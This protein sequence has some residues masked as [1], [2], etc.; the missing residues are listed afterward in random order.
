[1][2]A[3][4]NTS[5]LTAAT[6]A[7]LPYSVS[8]D[9]RD[10]GVTYDVWYRWTAP[11][12][13]VV[14][15]WGR[16]QTYGAYQVQVDIYEDADV[17]LYLNLGQLW[18]PVNVPI[19]VPMRSGHVYYMNFYTI[20]SLDANPAV[21]EL[22]VTDG[23]TDAIRAG[24]F[25]TNLEVDFDSEYPVAV[26]AGDADRTVRAY[27]QVSTPV[28]P[29]GTGGLPHGAIGAIFSNGNVAWGDEQYSNVK[30]YDASLT[31][32][33]TILNASGL[34]NL[35]L[36][37]VLQRLY[38]ASVGAPAGHI[39]ITSYDDAGVV[40]NTWD[41]TITTIRSMGVN[42]DETILYYSRGGEAA[43]KRW[44][45]I[46]NSAMADLAAD[47]A[48]YTIQDVLVLEDDT[49]IAL[50]HQDA[51]TFHDAYARHYSA[52]GALLQTY[53]FGSFWRGSL[54]PPRAGFALDSPTSFW[55]SL[56]PEG[57]FDTSLLKNVLISNGSIVTTR[58]HSNFLGGISLNGYDQAFGK[59]PGGATTLLTAAFD[60]TVTIAI[61]VQET[62]ADNGSAQPQFTLG[63]TATPDAFFAAATFVD[64]VA[65]TG[66]TTDAVLAAGDDLVVTVVAGTG[67]STG[68]LHVGLYIPDSISDYGG[69]K[70][71]A[72]LVA[73]V[74]SAG[75]PA[76]PSGPSALA[77]LRASGRLG[78]SN[79]VRVRR[80][81]HLADEAERIFYSKFQLDCEAGV[82]TVSGQ[83]QT[84]T[85]ELRW[86][87]D[88]GFTWSAW[89]TLG[90]GP[91]GQYRFRAMAWRLGYARDRVFE[92]RQ[93]DPVKTTWL[94]AYLDLD[95]G[96][97]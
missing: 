17:S 32:V 67:G 77:A 66:F 62:L 39:D 78:E 33:S 84:P 72:V 93:S 31:L 30:I 25:L 90:V 15:I 22:S 45:L 96:G 64:A 46:L 12:D 80:A 41:T 95:G 10:A 97:A 9:V 56:K 74:G 38:I 71:Y 52:A 6:I 88:G 3:P 8:Q 26:L 89:R 21:L 7:S 2:P 37:R 5:R 19:Y 14:T 35:G 48:G 87:D 49:I 82:G 51:G 24:D 13:Q 23:P 86:S 4:T 34:V 40:Q 18:T 70:S 60:Q 76:Q 1:M 69:E 75:P 58:T 27:M 83:G 20:G 91:Q 42:S 29:R 43:I 55:V 50:Y 63:T 94:T 16:G 44:D 85:L 79:I 68:A 65:G 92:V 47:V 28:Y 73:P 81:P 59:T 11:T 53:S 36:S 57:R 61:N 54:N